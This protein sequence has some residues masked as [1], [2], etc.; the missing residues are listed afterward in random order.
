MARRNSAKDTGIPGIAELGVVHDF[1]IMW[2][3]GKLMEC[4]SIF[5]FL[6]E[7]HVLWMVTEVVQKIRRVRCRN[8]LH[9]FPL[10]AAGAGIAEA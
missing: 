4:R 7:D 8:H 2:H 6:G 9:G 10:V 1:L 3:G 5:R